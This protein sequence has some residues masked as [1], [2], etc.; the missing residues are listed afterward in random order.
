MCIN[1]SLVDAH[2]ILQSN[3]HVHLFEFHDNSNKVSFRM[4]NKFF[5]LRPTITM[6]KK[7]EVERINV[8]FMQNFRSFLNLEGVR[9]STVDL[10]YDKKNCL[11]VEYRFCIGGKRIFNLP[12][13][14][15][16]KKWF[17]VGGNYYNKISGSDFYSQFFCPAKQK[18]HCFINYEE[19]K[20]K[21]IEKVFVNNEGV[22]C[23]VDC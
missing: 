11:T 1:K 8:D 6:W 12:K 20:N 17:E 14:C 21:W 7:D 16:E 13:D 4:S 22:M 5:Y 18:K 3:K 15:F 19:C 2:K 23:Q 10:G 9:I